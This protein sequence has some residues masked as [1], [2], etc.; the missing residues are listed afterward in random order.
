VTYTPTSVYVANDSVKVTAS[1]PA[2]SFFAKALTSKKVT[3]TVS[4]TA[5][6]TNAGGGALPWG[7]IKGTYTPGNTYPIFV[8]QSGPNFGSIR[9]PGWDTASQSC[10]TGGV[11]GV[12]RT[13]TPPR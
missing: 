4:A 13:C 1:K 9:L 12:G 7:V 8:D 10:T 11:V 3:T 5:T 2:Q 6:F